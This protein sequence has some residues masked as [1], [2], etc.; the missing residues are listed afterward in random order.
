MNKTTRTIIAVVLVVLIILIMAMCQRKTE[1]P[2]TPENA[3]AL[4][5]KMDETMNGLESMEMTVTTKKV[6]FQQGQ[7]HQFVGTNYVLSTKQAHYTHIKNL[8]QAAEMVEAYYDGKIYRA[9]KDDIHDQK[10]CSVMSH[11]EYDQLQT[12]ELTDGFQILDC[13]TAEYSE[14]ENGWNLTFS[15]YTKKTIDQMV[16]S[17]GLAEDFLGGSVQDM[18]VTIAADKDFYVREMKINFVFAPEAA[19]Y[20]PNF[21][22]TVAYSNLNTATFDPE[23]LKPEEYVEIED[24]RILETI[25]AAIAQRQNAQLGQFD[26]TIKTTEVF[27]EKT[28][29]ATETGSMVYGKKDSGYYYLFNIDIDGKSSEIRYENNVQTV[30]TGSQSYTGEMS[31]DEAAKVYVSS[32]ID[33]ARYNPLAINNI[34]KLEEGVYL[35]TSNTPDLSDYLEGIGISSANQQ[36]KITFKEG[37]LKKIESTLSFSGNYNEEAVEMTTEASVIFKDGEQTPEA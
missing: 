33:S 23:L 4:W 8:N 15:G 19:E 9:I 5:E 28:S 18:Q 13:K 31:E 1:P 26:I 7:W 36:I 35:L 14:E 21:S 30:T 2:Y 11:E 24:I 34:E 29:T 16:M 22:V 32:L 27:R 10:F 20:K 3:A 17:A 12:G 6:Y 25:S 37:M